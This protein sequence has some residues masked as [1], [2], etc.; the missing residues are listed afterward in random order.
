MDLVGA[1]PCPTLVSHLPSWKVGNFL[2]LQILS[3]SSESRM[4]VFAAD[5]LQVAT[6]GATCFRI[7]KLNA[8]CLPTALLVSGENLGLGS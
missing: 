2:I 4:A 7:E 6:A 8:E 3:S 5:S 1:P